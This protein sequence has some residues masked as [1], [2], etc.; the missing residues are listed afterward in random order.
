MIEQY[1]G[2]RC[3]LNSSVNS[4]LT[5]YIVQR[6]KDLSKSIQVFFSRQLYKTV[7][8]VVSFKMYII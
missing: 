1:I 8:K 3:A 5:P 2:Y 7:L 6:M 4:Y